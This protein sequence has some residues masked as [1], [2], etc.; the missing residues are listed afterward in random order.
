MDKKKL[1]RN[2]FARFFIHCSCRLLDFIE[3]FHDHKICGCSLVKYVPSKFRESMGA[4]GS[5]STRYLVLKQMFSG[6]RFSSSDRLIDIG[7]GKGRVLAYMLEN[8]FPGS[9]YGIELN[10]DVAHYAQSWTKKY[11][12]VTIIAGDAFKQD[13]DYYDLFF[14]NRPFETETFQK[15][16]LKFEQE[17]THPARMYYWV[18]QISGGFLKD[19]DGWKLERREWLNR[20]G[21]LYFY[22]YPQRYS[23]WEYTP[24]CCRE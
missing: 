3:V 19:R 4:T 18:D 22:P 11:D 9:L 21:L 5:Q 24:A 10:E 15:F 17:L 2:P 13:L 14:L 1:R 23:V 20:K 8:R 7:C 16:I 6:E 12:G